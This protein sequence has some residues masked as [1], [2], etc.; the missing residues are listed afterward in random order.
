MKIRLAWVGKTKEQFIREGIQKYIKLIKPFADLSISEI[1]EEKGKDIQR[2]IEKESER[3]LKDNTHYVLLDERGK[4]ISTVEFAE[5]IDKQRS[6][7]NFVIGGAYGVSDKVREKSEKYIALS[8]MTFTHE[9]SRLVILEQI[10]RALAILNK[11]GYH[12]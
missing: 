12:H 6:P 7:V 2:M 11:R 10:Y 9:M 5:F 4:N 8:K 3:I 1:K